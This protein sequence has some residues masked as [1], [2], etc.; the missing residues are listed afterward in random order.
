MGMILTATPSFRARRIEAGL[1]SAG[2]DF[3]NNTN[4]FTVGLGRF[5]DL[6]KGDFIG[7]KTL[8][9]ADKKC[10]SW[11]IRVVDGIA[12]KGRFIKLNDQTIGKVTSSTWS[13]YQVC[14]V[15]IIL[16]DK[17]DIGPG[18][19]VEVECTDEKIHKAELCKLPMYDPKGEIVRGI[20]KK[21]PTK[22]EPWSGI[23][24]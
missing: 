4:P 10:R 24:N 14:G 6:E 19:V 18:S 21:I 8:L 7:K 2:Q 1:L 11:G 9:N 3:T 12:K 23:K 16:L 15:G 22:A 20:D 17:A 13:P 5:V